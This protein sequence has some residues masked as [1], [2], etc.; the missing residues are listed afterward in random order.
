MAKMMNVL[1]MRLLRKTVKRMIRLLAML[2]VFTLALPLACALAD[3]GVSS[4]YTYNYNYWG[5]LRESPDAYRVEQS[6]YSATLGLETPMR[7]PQSL[8]VYEND[9]YVCDTGNNRILQLH[10]FPAHTIEEYKG[11]VG[12]GMR[13]LL[14][15]ERDRTASAAAVR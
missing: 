3:D 11:F 12:D 6:I 8:Y 7:R 1:T 15:Q 14:E 2:T 5:G 10:G 13:M 4:T 9:L